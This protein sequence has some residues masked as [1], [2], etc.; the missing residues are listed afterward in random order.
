MILADSE[1]VMV[2]ACEFVTVMFGGSKFTV[3]AA[4]KNS[5]RNSR[6]L[7]SVNANERLSRAST[8]VNPGL[9][10]TCRPELPKLNP[11]AG[12]KQET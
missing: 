12:V 7:L 9:T 2:P 6:L 1:L 10:I 11:V 5:A 3:L 8:F 4:L